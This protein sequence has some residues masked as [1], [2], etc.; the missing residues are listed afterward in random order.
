MGVRE[1]NKITVNYYHYHRFDRPPYNP[2]ASNTIIKYNTTPPHHPL[3]AS[4]SWWSPVAPIIHLFFRF[5]KYQKTKTE[6]NDIRRNIS[7][8][9]PDSS[10]TT[11]H[12]REMRGSIHKNDF[13]ASQNDSRLTIGEGLTVVELILL[14]LSLYVS[15]WETEVMVLVHILNK[16]S[17]TSRIRKRKN[18]APA[19][20]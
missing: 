12:M 1:D 11:H 8:E 20:K 19:G 17:T 14:Y 4:L 6:I 3:P 13:I 7:Q 10:Y 16:K 2:H 15:V 5:F 18:T 9:L